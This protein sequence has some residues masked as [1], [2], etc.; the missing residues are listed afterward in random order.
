M[1]YDQLTIHAIISIIDVYDKDEPMTNDV[2]FVIDDDDDMKYDDDG[3]MNLRV[4]KEIKYPQRMKFLWEIKDENMMKCII[5]ENNESGQIVMSQIFGMYKLKWYL[6]LHPILDDD[7]DDPDE[8][9]HD[10]KHTFHVFLSLA[11]KSP[12]IESVTVQFG[13]VVLETGDEHCHYGQLYGEDLSIGTDL[14]S[15]QRSILCGLDTLSIQVFVN[16]LQ[17]CDD[18]GELITDQFIDVADDDKKYDDDDI[19]MAKEVDF[20]YR[21]YEWK[22]DDNK[23]LKKM[24]RAKQFESFSSDIFVING[25]KF[26][27]QC[28]P[29]GSHLDNKGKFEWF[30]CLV[31]IPTSIFKVSVIYNIYLIELGITDNYRMELSLKCTSYGWGTKKLKFKQISKLKQI[32]FLIEIAVIDVYDKDGNTVT[33][34]YV[35]CDN[36]NIS[37]LSKRRRPTLLQDYIWKIKDKEVLQ[38]M[39]LAKNME[40]FKSETWSVIDIHLNGI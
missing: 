15:P 2:K 17:V 21:D 1:P 22:I 13:F 23:L 25:F 11:T 6:E 7:D 38:Q 24:K 3:G 37:N 9:D 27:M 20:V 39:K 8:A 28:C 36:M 35:S 29:N 32:T 30:L 4:C 10:Q 18:D 34:N 40:S 33:N 16:I 14:V 26:M 19:K 5:N 12:K 31:S